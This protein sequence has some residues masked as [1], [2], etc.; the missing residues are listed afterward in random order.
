[1]TYDIP[2]WAPDPDYW[3]K[4]GPDDEDDDEFGD[5]DDL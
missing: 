5:D 4:A 3:K 1:M 2:P